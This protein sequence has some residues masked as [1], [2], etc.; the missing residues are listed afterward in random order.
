MHATFLAQ[1]S[2]K[3]QAFVFYH[4]HFLLQTKKPRSGLSS[5]DVGGQLGSCRIPTSV[6]PKT[7]PSVK[8]SYLYFDDP[9]KSGRS[10]LRLTKPCVAFSIFMHR[11]ADARRSPFISKDNHVGEILRCSAISAL[12]PRGSSLKYSIKV[13]VFFLKKSRLLLR[14]NQVI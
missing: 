5:F 4:F 6:H 8:Q 10:S 3:I 13:I 11:A 7:P 9:N 1:H 2:F 12:E 14:G